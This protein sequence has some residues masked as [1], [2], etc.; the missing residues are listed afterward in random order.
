MFDVGFSELVVIALLALIVLGP[1]RLPE[2]ARTAGRWMAKVRHF[3]SEVRHDLDREMRNAEILELQKLKQE[4]DETKRLMQETSNR[5]MQQAGIVDSE[6]SL[7]DATA[8]TP[9]LAATPAPKQRA[10]RKRTAKKKR[11]TKSVTKSHGRTRFR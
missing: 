5:V 1:K 9:A 6:A 4:L 11:A 3:V 2:V 8:S 10:T 7:I